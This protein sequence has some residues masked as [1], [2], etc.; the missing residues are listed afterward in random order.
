MYQQ[1]CGN[2]NRIGK[3]LKSDDGDVTYTGLVSKVRYGYGVRVE[4]L[5]TGKGIGSS[6]G[7]N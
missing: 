6:T 2:G 4:N 7:R 1:G 5:V 3:L